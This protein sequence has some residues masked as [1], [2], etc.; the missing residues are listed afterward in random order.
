ME[1]RQHVF[2]Q[3]QPFAYAT[4][5]RVANPVECQSPDMTEQELI[6]GCI[7][8][9]RTCQELFYKQFYGKMLGVCLR[10]AKNRDEARDMLQ[11]GF[12][13]VFSAL[14]NFAGRGS[15][16]GWVRRIMV[17]TS[18]D[19]LRRNKHEYLIVSTV[20]MREGDVPDRIDEVEE[21]ALMS[22]LSEEQILQAVQQLSP[23]YRT[24]F[25]LYVIENLQHKEIAVQL[26]ISEGTSKSNLAKARYQLQKN[27]HLMYRKT[28]DGQR[29]IT[30]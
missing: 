8:Q 16:E 19:H 27:L 30:R 17:N 22:A 2:C 9:D 21:E 10:Y 20:S 5:F 11:E 13:K 15:L 24:V 14:R 7:R 3:K 1:T 18:V 25:N 6:A 26:N 4:V 28:A 12:I 23:A 29:T